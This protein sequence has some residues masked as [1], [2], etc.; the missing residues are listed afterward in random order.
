MNEK[1]QVTQER[2]CY[3]ERKMGRTLGIMKEIS[4]QQ[5]SMKSQQRK[6]NNFIPHPQF[7]GLRRRN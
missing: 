7:L 1:S 3:E 4:R 2:L 6:T 5:K